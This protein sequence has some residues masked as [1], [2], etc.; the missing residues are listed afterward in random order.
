MAKGWESKPVR[1]EIDAAA[2]RSAAERSHEVSS[3]TLDLLRKKEIILMSRTR[4]LREMEN[5]QNPRYKAVLSKALADLDAQLT[6]LALPEAA[7]EVAAETTRVIPARTRPN[8]RPSKDIAK[9]LVIATAA[10]DDED[11]AGRWLRE[12]NIQ[13]GNAP[14]VSL[15]GTPEGFAVVESV[16]HQIQYGVFG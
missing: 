5:T 7:R 13:T 8:N 11:K 6:A 16:L 3:E 10:F 15:V 14:P 4:V 12:P 1:A 2:E 9:I